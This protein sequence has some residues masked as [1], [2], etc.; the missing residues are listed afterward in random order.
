MISE[1]QAYDIA[2]PALGS[3]VDGWTSCE[4]RS[5]A[6]MGEEPAV[7]TLSWFGSDGSTLASIRIDAATGEILP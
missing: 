5:D 6:D 4:T 2:Y 1:S 7:W 3:S